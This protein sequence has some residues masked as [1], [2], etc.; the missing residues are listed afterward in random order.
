MTRCILL[1]ALVGPLAFVGTIPVGN[2]TGLPGA[3][4]PAKLTEDAKAAADF[5]VREEAKR[6]AVTLKLVSVSKVEKQIVAGI[7]FRLALEVKKGGSTRVADAV[8]FRDLK[9]RYQLTSWKWLGD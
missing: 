3:Y 9:S 6:E 5:A 8:V 7:N 4:A 1:A 2:A